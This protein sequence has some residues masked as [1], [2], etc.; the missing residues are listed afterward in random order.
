MD[1]PD[2]GF[3]KWVA[4]ILTSILGVMG[5]AFFSLIR[6]FYDGR[7]EE[8]KKE[9]VAKIETVEV[10]VEDQDVKV[11]SLTADVKHLRGIS[12]EHDTAIAEIRVHNRHAKEQRGR[13]EDAVTNLDGKIDDLILVVNGGTNR[14]RSGK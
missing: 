13:I 3:W 2:P 9:L 5:L 10:R 11:T 7:F 1:S 8:M 12:A 14:N 4:G 6:K